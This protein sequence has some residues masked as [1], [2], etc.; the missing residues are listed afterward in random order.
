MSRRKW[1]EWLGINETRLRWRLR[2]RQQ[3][4]ASRP[5]SKG[6]L[7]RQCPSCGA[8]LAYDQARC[9]KCQARLP[10]RHLVA[11]SRGL[12]AILP[13]ENPSTKLILAILL[14]FFALVSLDG[15]NA[16]G[17]DGVVSALLAPPAEVLWRWGAHVRGQPEPWRLV[18]S[19]F[20]HFGILHIFFN[21]SALRVAGPYV[22]RFFGSALAFTLFVLTGIGAMTVS[23][24]LGHAGIA[25]GA[26]GSLMGFLGLAAAAGQRSKTRFGSDVRS[27]MLRWALFVMFFGIAAELTGMMAIDNIAHGAGFV[28]G[29]GLGWVVPLRELGAWNRPKVFYLSFAATLLAVLLSVYG[30]TGMVMHRLGERAF[31]ECVERLQR[32]DYS[33]A[34]PSCEQAVERNAGFPGAYHNLAHAYLYAE[35][36]EEAKAVCQRAIARF[37]RDKMAEYS[38]LCVELSDD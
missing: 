34:I 38:P 27:Q 5:S 22:E 6:K 17:G 10:S 24:F 19:N 28:I 2:Q 30:V 31:N 14:G 36:P 13:D 18:M 15:I 16:L 9:D 20:L 35:R 11:L 4:R 3:K 32:R 1:Y 26:S 37:G 12:A 8:L 21:A 7:A 29:Y 33:D 23:N 25:A